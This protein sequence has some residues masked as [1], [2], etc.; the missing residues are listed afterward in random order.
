MGKGDSYWLFKCSCGREKVMRVKAVKWNLK[1][2][3]NV[4][5]GASVHAPR[6][7]FVDLTGKQIGELT[8]LEHITKYGNRS[9]WKCRCSCGKN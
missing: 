2:N 3:G 1:K 5:C 6:T 7:N 8:V 9:Y 4:T